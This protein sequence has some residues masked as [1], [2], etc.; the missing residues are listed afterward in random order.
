MFALQ[1]AYADWRKD[2]GVFRIGIAT[3]DGE[4]F[5]EGA[6]E[7]FRAQASR[8]LAMPVEI[9]QAR[10]A[11]SLIDAAASSRIEYAILSSLGFVTLDL[12]CDCA[13]PIAA[14]SSAEG[15]TATRS[16]LIVDAKEVASLQDLAGKRLA[17][18]PESS[19]TG[20]I[21]PT[22]QF[23]LD[24]TRLRNADFELV[25]LDSVEQA[26][27]ALANGEVAGFFGWDQ[28]DPDSDKV[29][30]TSLSKK[31]ERYPELST[32][33]VWASEPI[34]YGPHIINKTVPSEA[35]TALRS[36]LE[37]LHQTSPLV[38]QTISPDLS[39]GLK[40]VTAKDYV[41]AYSLIRSIARDAAEN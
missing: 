22:A 10:D 7:G 18:G 14:P 27:E 12:T 35:A 19:L 39:G 32:N 28:V 5:K 15:A 8:A 23:S 25:E 2:M 29:F 24:G 3:K 21:L 38:Y 37:S 1:P 4:P 30:E 33:V 31:L 11:S 26:V 40:S 20:S 34:R 41:S 36:M 6:L 13:L 9:F 17:I 16:V